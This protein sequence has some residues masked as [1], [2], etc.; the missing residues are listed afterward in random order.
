MIYSNTVGKGI[1]MLS[2]ISFIG[3][4]L[5]KYLR[6]PTSVR[7][8]RSLTSS[9][10]SVPSESSN[11]TL[12]TSSSLDTDTCTYGVTSMSTITNVSHLSLT[13][14]LRKLGVCGKSEGLYLRS[15]FKNL[16]RSR[17]ELIQP[18]RGDISHDHDFADDSVLR[19]SVLGPHQCR[20]IQHVLIRGPLTPPQSGAK[21]LL[22]ITADRAVGGVSAVVMI[23]LG[24]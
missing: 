22:G 14:S 7:S 21:V 12:A 1:Y 8:L 5:S 15:I 10:P 9:K 11:P 24:L 17:S 13:H 2:L 18:N 6:F 4:I 20:I 19:G 23:G 3:Y 16:S